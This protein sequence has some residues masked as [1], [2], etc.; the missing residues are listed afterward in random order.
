MD[1]FRRAG[2][3]DE[4][5]LIAFSED[6]EWAYRALRSG[7]SVAYVPDAVVTHFGWRDEDER[8][9][10]YANY[11]RSH[12]A[13]FGKYL[14]RFDAFIMLRSLIHLLRSA[15]RWAQGKMAGDIEQANYA[16]AYL[17]QFVPGIV[18]GLKSTERPPSLSHTDN[19][20]GLKG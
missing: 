10:Q 2:L 16:A 9:S 15:R 18:A 17:R 5:P 8:N 13:F 20:D 12:A 14:R 11:A 7:I 6:G 3:F 1:V 19:T 4:D